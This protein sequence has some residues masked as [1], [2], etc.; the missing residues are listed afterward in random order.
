MAGT[1]AALGS[2][3]A[4]EVFSED[5]SLL[6]GRVSLPMPSPERKVKGVLLRYL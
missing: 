6:F 2:A 1:V 5:H 4:L 3:A